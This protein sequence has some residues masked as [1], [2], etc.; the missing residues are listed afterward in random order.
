MGAADVL[1]L[2]VIALSVLFGLWRG[3]IGELLALAMWVLAFW[4]AWQ[5]GDRVAAQL[6]ASISAPALRLFVA[7]GVIFVLVLIAGAVLGWLLRL[8][9]QGSGLGGTDRLL[10]MLFGAVRGLLIVTLAVLLAGMTPLPRS[11]FWRQSA[12]L[13]WFQQAA[14]SLQAH[15]P[16]Q[17]ARYVNYPP[18]LAALPLPQTLRQVLPQHSPEH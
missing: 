16:P 3:L 7:W 6:P 8:L 4:A 10:G 18:P 12:L 2:A 14:Q 17:V 5:F 9:V 1:I 13:P 11:A 15:L